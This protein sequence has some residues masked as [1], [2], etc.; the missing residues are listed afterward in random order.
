MITSKFVI[1]PPDF[2]SGTDCLALPL[3]SRSTCSGGT[4]LKRLQETSASSS[5]SAA[6]SKHERC[7]RGQAKG[8][9]PT[10]L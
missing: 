3:N 7:Q 2:T 9:D 4:W 8:I 6:P 1:A 5:S 10:N